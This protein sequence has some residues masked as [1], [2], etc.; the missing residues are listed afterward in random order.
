MI[1]IVLLF[2]IH[3]GGASS[4]RIEIGDQ[5]VRVTLTFPLDEISTGARLDSN[6]DGYLD[7]GEYDAVLPL[8]FA[9]V[10]DRFQVWNQ[11]EPC[12]GELVRG[13]F[14]GDA[15]I[16][17]ASLRAPLGLELRYRSSR[18]VGALRIRCRLFREH[19][20]AHRHLIDFPDGRSALLDRN[21]DGT[22]W[23][24]PAALG[25]TPWTAGGSIALLLGLLCTGLRACARTAIPRQPGD[26]RARW[27]APCA[28]RSAWGDSAPCPSPRGSPSSSA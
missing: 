5:E 21:R 27:H 4:S 11:D 19:S 25:M 26:A 22:E 2:L 7:R 18:P 24:A 13:R 14:A 28:S 12:A 8:L 1:P 3:E 17:L 10:R 6:G 9:Y 16:P 20:D 23:Q 15:P